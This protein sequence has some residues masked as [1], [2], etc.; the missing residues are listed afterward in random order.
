M[1][2]DLHKD[3]LQL[4]NA[5]NWVLVFADLVVTARPVRLLHLL[6]PI[7]LGIIYTLISA[8]GFM[9]FNPGGPTNDDRLLFLDWN[10]SLV[11]KK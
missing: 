9:H 10:K 4:V 11:S 3:T 5:L 2:S 1:I 6:H 7:V 8:V